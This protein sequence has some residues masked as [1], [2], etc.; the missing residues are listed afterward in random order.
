MKTLMEIV[1]IV[2]NIKL[3]P[4][5]FLSTSQKQNSKVNIFYKKLTLGEFESDL[6]ASKFFFSSDT[7]DFKFIRK[8]SRY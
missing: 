8:K 7:N 1:Q 6:D 5:D 4:T 2:K 3:K